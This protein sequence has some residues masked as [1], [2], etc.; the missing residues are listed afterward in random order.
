MSRGRNAGSDY[1]TT[2]PLA[3]RPV[4]SRGS[5]RHQLQAWES[6]SNS[7]ILCPNWGFENRAVGGTTRLDSNP[8]LRPS[9]RRPPAIMSATRQWSCSSP[10]T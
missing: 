8:F 2:E 3:R 7:P 4:A 9:F 5:G 1:V 10:W 6:A